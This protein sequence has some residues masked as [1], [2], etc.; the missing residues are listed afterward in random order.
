MATTSAT[1]AKW[2]LEFDSAS[3]KGA[4]SYSKEEI[5]LMTARGAARAPEGIVNYNNNLILIIRY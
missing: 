2:R 5:L 3:Q 4:V 1:M